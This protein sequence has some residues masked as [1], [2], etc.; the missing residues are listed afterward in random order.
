MLHGETSNHGVRCIETYNWDATSNSLTRL[1][2]HRAPGMSLHKC[3]RIYVCMLARLSF[4][5]S[6][7]LLSLTHFSLFHLS[8]STPF[9]FKFK[10]VFAFHPV[11]SGE[12]GVRSGYLFPSL[13]VFHAFS[14]CYKCHAFLCAFIFSQ[15]CTFPVSKVIFSKVKLFYNISL[16]ECARLYFAVLFVSLHLHCP[17]HHRMETRF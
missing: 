1:H 15:L 17:Y 14:T 6:L 7:T 8:S 16:C 4:D 12:R 13:R 3:I 2:P 5:T 9:K 10:C 11:E